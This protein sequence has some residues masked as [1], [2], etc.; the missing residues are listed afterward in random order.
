MKQLGSRLIDEPAK[1][2][3]LTVYRDRSR[4][5]RWRL[6][7]KNGAIIADSGESYSRERDC[8]RAVQRLPFRFFEIGLVR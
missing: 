5:Y 7:H 2:Y 1:T 4:Q 6:S 8:W 3:R